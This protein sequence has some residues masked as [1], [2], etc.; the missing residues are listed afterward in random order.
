MEVSEP[1]IV[2]NG[3]RQVLD[4]TL[5]DGSQH[6]GKTVSMK[7]GFWENA[8]TEPPIFKELKAA[9]ETKKPVTIYRL[10]GKHNTARWVITNTRATLV[11]ATPVN[12]NLDYT[13]LAMV[14]D[15]DNAKLE[16]EYVLNDTACY[17]NDLT[18]STTVALLQRLISEDTVAKGALFQVNWGELM[19]PAEIKFDKQTFQHLVQDQ[20]ARPHRGC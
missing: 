18:M 6:Q 11:I 13:A 9:W 16:A 10:N 7:V 5:E 14:S 15:N 19:P 17:K 4:V 20:S 12:M 2:G 8:G 1:K 3:T